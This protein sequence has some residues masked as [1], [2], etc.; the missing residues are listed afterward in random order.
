MVCNGVLS[1]TPVENSAYKSNVTLENT[2]IS[3]N[4]VAWK[5][6]EKCKNFAFPNFNTRK[7]GEISVFTQCQS[8]IYSYDK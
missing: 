1:P 7:A 2:E 6:W 8:Q 4:F 3:P 5:F